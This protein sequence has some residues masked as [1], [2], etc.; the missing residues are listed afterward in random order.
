MERGDV[1]QVARY[2]SVLP[3]WLKTRIYANFLI[4]IRDEDPRKHALN[5]ATQ[6]GLDVHAI[7]SLVVTTIRY[8]ESDSFMKLLPNVNH[9][10][11]T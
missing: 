9:P 8:S 1:E 6:V 4:H 5:L 7:T 10:I 3:D 2:T 11:K